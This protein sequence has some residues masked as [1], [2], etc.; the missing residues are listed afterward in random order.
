MQGFY[1]GSY[2]IIQDIIR[3]VEWKGVCM[4]EWEGF[5]N[6]K[7]LIFLFPNLLIQWNPNQLQVCIAMV[8]NLKGKKDKQWEGRCSSLPD[9]STQCSSI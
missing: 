7:M 3:K 8:P 9:P 2:K 6:V 4:S 5:S 1:E